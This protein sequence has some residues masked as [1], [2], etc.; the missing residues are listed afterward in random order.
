MVSDLLEKNKNSKKTAIRFGDTSIS[1]SEWYSLSMGLSKELLKVCSDNT[2]TVALFLPNS[3]AYAIA[4]FGCLFSNK[5]IVPINVKEKE[6]EIL[7]TVTYCEIDIILT[8]SGYKKQLSNSLR[9]SEF[10]HII[11]DVDEYT[12]IEVNSGYSSIPKNSDLKSN[13]NDNDVAIM[14]HTSGTTTNQKRVMLTNENLTSNVKS[15]VASLQLTAEDK[16]LIALPMVFGYCNT[17]QFLSHLY[18]GATIVISDI[19]FLPKHFFITVEKERITS[20]TGVPSMLLMLLQYRSFSKY[21]YSSLK[22]ICFGGGSMPQE[23]LREL[24]Y[25]FQSISFI[26]TYGITECS[27]RVT[28]LLGDFSL[29]KLGSVG[30]AIPGVTVDIVDE[31]WKTVNHY[32]TGEIIVS[33]PNVMKGYF[34]HPDLT[35]Q[36]IRDGWLKT[37]D[38]GYFDEDGFIFLIGRVKNII[39]SGGI[40]IYPEE[41]EQI[42][43]QHKEIVDAYVYGEEDDYLGEVPVAQVVLNNN[44]QIIKLQDYCFRFLSDYKVPVRF[45]IVNELVKTYNGKVKRIRGD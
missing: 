10:R 23:K 24:I 7:N 33:G 21:N 31:K 28:A 13:R 6:P 20:F 1:F 32:Q 45:Y 40:N 35:A 41:I 44:V 18:L 19:L 12:Y 5:V 11:Y 38:I 43:M 4:Y 29:S 39:I 2:I 25:R 16:V 26:H 22:Y 30:K 37:G 8:S 42:L 15:H 9:H 34:K 3:I 27:P 14:L 36:V 17:A